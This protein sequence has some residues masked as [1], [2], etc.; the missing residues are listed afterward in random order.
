MIASLSLGN[1]ADK[2]HYPSFDV[3]LTP[4]RR[5]QVAWRSLGEFA[6]TARI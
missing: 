5:V 4:M 1:E 6:R 3:F 2:L